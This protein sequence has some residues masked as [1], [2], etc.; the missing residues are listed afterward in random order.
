MDKKCTKAEMEL[1]REYY[2]WQIID[3]LVATLA[4]VELQPGDWIVSTPDGQKAYPDLQFKALFV[5]VS[6]QFREVN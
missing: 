6:G 3:G 1:P 4:G 2:A 5:P